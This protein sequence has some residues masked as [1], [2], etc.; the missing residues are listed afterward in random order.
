MVLTKNYSNIFVMDCTYKTNKYKM[1]LLDIIG[2]S[3]FNTSFFSCFVF[4]QKEEEEDYVWALTKFGKILGIDNYPLVI[5]S[6]RELALMNAIKVVFP[7]TTNLLCVWHIEKNIL[8]N[9]KRHF[10]KGED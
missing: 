3:S 6:D 4:L 1:P 2:I 5:V 7:R 9:C 8:V 10:E